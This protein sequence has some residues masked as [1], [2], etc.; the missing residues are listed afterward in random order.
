M[1]LLATLREFGD[2]KAPIPLF[3][4][5]IAIMLA[6]QMLRPMHD[7]DIFWQLRFGELTLDHG[8]PT[9]EPFL[10]NR[11]DEPATVVAWL[12]QAGYAQVRRWGNWSLL[13]VVDALI[14]F[15]GFFVV[16]RAFYRRGGNQFPIIAALGIGWFAAVPFAGLRPQS[17][18]VAAFGLL[19]VLL[20]SG[21][22][23]RCTIPLGTVLLV[24]WQNLHPSVAV[25]VV[26]LGSVVAAE[27]GTYWMRGGKRPSLGGIVLIPIAVGAIFATPQGFDI[28]RVTSANQA[29]CTSDLLMIREWLPMWQTFPDDGR[30]SA[31]L[32]MM[33]SLFLVV[34]SWNRIHTRDLVPAIVLGVMTLVMFRFVIF[35]G[36]A[37]IPVVVQCLTIDEEPIAP[38]SPTRERWSM[39]VAFFVGLLPILA[40][41]ANFDRGFP[42]AGIKAMKDAEVRG[43]IFSN[44]HG[45][46]MLIDAGFPDWSITQD[47]RYY[48]YSAEQLEHY[49]A[50][51][52]GQIP[53]AQLEAETNPAA[54]FLRPSTDQGLIE[55]L[56]ATSPRWEVL[57]EDANS[58]VFVRGKPAK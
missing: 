30:A 27:W 1:K 15:G 51:T 54:F 40:V 37:I 20:R 10:A 28:L 49:F 57:F 22:S 21:W 50:A 46:G 43:T 23:A 42:F 7:C 39:L 12:G 9:H 58:L 45:G 17:F 26:Y 34:W 11:S 48:L 33:V 13:R 8:L 18:A 41:G 31:S 44:H 5:C 52:Q 38:S 32:M 19:V 56:R 6:V 25:A 2:P 55:L 14:W 35:W 53:V 24:L 47:G 4:L 36:I 16:A 3:P 29:R